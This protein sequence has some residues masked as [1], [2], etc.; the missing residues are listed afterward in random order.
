M[1]LLL[2]HFPSA[3]SFFLPVCTSH[4]PTMLYPSHYYFLYFSSYVLP[5]PPF[6]LSILTLL[7]TIYF[8]LF[9][10]STSISP[11]LLTPLYVSLL[12]SFLPVYLPS[13]FS[14]FSTLFP[15]LQLGLDSV[16]MTVGRVL[17]AS[18]L[19]TLPATAF[20]FL[21]CC[22]FPTFLLHAPCTL[23]SL[24][25]SVSLPFCLFCLSRLLI[26]YFL[27]LLPALG[28]ALLSLPLLL[29][30]FL[31]FFPFCTLPP[32]LSFSLPLLFS[33]TSSCC[34]KLCYLP[35][36]LLPVPFFHSFH[37]FSAHTACEPAPWAWDRPF[38]HLLLPCRWEAGER[39]SGRER[40]RQT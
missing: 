9:S 15:L 27:L 8:L 7:L 25:F 10:L 36:T 5:F 38:L 23:F 30:P 20:Y 11:C 17:P 13:F 1:V 21:C 3:A 14:R 32:S 2:L 28:S 39:A 19:P 37:C 18:A 4:L 34:Y 31:L 16:V 33:V 40:Q 24:S 26:S 22:Y 12:F 29:L 35:A 6:C